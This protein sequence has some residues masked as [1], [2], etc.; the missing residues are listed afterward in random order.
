MD[1]IDNTK[2]SQMDMSERLPVPKGEEPKGLSVTPSLTSFLKP[3]ADYL[4]TELRDYV[5]DK[6]EGL[7]AKKRKSNVQAHMHVVGIQLGIPL[8]YDEESLEAIPQ[9]ELFD[10]WIGGAQ[11]VDPRDETLAKLWQGLLLEIVQGKSKNRVLI[12]TLKSLDSHEAELLLKFKG[13]RLFHP[14]GNEERFILRKLKSLE[15]I[16]FDWTFLAILGISYVM[17]IVMFVSIPDMGELAFGKPFNLLQ[18]SLISILPVATMAALVP[19]YK[20]SWLGKRLLDAAPNISK[21]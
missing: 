2:G 3:T 21:K 19:K 5:K 16:E 13:R 15:L 14:K 17:A 12:N 4:G 6:V 11:E 9:L 8:N 10:D 20:T 7:K 1:E 18:L